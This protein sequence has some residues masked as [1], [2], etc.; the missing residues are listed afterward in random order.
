MDQIVC[1][2]RYL[3]MQQYIVSPSAILDSLIELA[4]TLLNN[5]SAIPLSFLL[6]HKMCSVVGNWRQQVNAKRLKRTHQSV[7]GFRSLFIEFRVSFPIAIQF[8]ISSVI[9]ESTFH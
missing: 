6:W 8:I 7:V 3:N 5:V 1:A 2:T 4:L 9:R